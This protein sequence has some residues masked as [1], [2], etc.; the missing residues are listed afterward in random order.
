M[1]RGDENMWCEWIR[2]LLGGIFSTLINIG[3]FSILR[4]AGGFERISANIISVIA[5]ILFAF[6][7]NRFYVFKKVGKKH[8]WKEFIAF[9]GMRGSSMGVEVFGMELLTKICHIP[10]LISKVLIQT[11]VIAMNYIISK[12]YVFHEK[13]D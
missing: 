12:F 3:T 10:E 4:Y 11:I 7:I 1:G 5:A 2:Y 8:I 6:I 9:A 13:E